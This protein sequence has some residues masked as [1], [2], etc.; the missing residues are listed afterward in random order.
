LDTYREVRARMSRLCRRKGPFMTVADVA[1]APPQ[2][3]RRGAVVQRWRALPTMI[4]Y[5][6]A[7][8]LTQVIYLA[9]LSAA[10]WSGTF[11]VGALVLA[12]V[13]AMTFAFPT[14]RNVVFVAEGSLRRQLGTF[15]GVWWTGAAMS[16]LGVPV[17]VE[18]AGLRPLAAQLAVL[19]LVV[20]MSYVGHRNITFKRSVREAS[21]G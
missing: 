10:L 19:V 11:Y 12:Q 8:G 4:R 15:L 13:A 9:T 18:I 7:G 1:T 20:L 5:G 3:N 21:R 14:Y 16:L 17:L 2:A 6:L